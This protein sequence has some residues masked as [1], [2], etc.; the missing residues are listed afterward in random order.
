MKKTLILL[1]LVQAG[2]TVT[3][4]H[5][6]TPH[7]KGTGYFTNPVFAGDYPDPSILRDGNDY[8]IVHSSF[9]YY[10]GL[11]IWHSTDLIN[12]APVTNALHRYVG[13]V[14]APD[15]VKHKGR[16]YIYFPANNTNFVVTAGSIRGPWSD[17]VDLKIGNIDPGHVTDDQG[18]RYLYFSSGGY[19]PLSEDGL[20]VTGEIRQAYDGWPIP[21]EWTIE[22]FC[23][24]GP[25][26]MKRGDY[27]YL[28]VAEGGTAGPA[29]SHMV[30]SARSQSPFGPWENSP[31]NPIIRTGDKSE[32]WWSKGH[33]TVFEDGSGNGWIVFHGYEKDHHNMGRQTLLQPVEWTSDGWYKTPEG[34][35]TEE[36]M[37]RPA[38]I[39]MDASF[40]LNDSFNDDALRPH[41]KFYG[42]YDPG[43]FHLSDGCLSIKARGQSVSDCSPLLSIPSD[44]S[45]IAQVEL[46]IEGEATGGLVLFYNPDAHSGILA[47]R[48]NILADLRGWQF[49]T[50][51]NVIRNRVFLR[52]KK[53]DS[54]VDMYYSPDGEQWNKI[55]SSLEVSSL[56]H[57]ALG[58]F[59]SLRIGLCSFGEGAVRFKNFS[60][61][62]MK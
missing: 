20:S 39:L 52:L 54:V 7:T 38:G 19:V 37:K 27:Y 57:N 21:R 25:K 62:A 35:R 18:K 10:P 4:Q 31:F 23:L 47:D 28:T 48:E 45:Y 33:G 51:K 1:L 56:N 36:P 26:L 17:P 30:I 46:L 12:W 3:A 44:H 43:R 29:T 50:E 49:T 41:W 9:E 22:C 8:Y 16:Y 2:F 34:I 53:T 11:L 59:L 42:E 24:E 55:E 14:W 32:R 6:T 5:Q 15:L 13:S 40:S 58:G 60:Y 61:Q